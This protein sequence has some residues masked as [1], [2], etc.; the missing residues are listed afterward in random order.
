MVDILLEDMR[1][2]AYHGVLEQEEKVGNDFI[3]SL[4]LQADVD[5]SIESDD[6]NHTIDYA[7]V[8]QVVKEEMTI[9]S[10]LLEHLAGR[11]VKRLFAQFL[12]IKSI[13]IKV[14]K[15]QPPFHS[16]LKAVSIQLTKNRN[17]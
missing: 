2:Y 17:E 4:S 3:V 7:Q 12:S 8:Y 15:P 16:E 13:I 14:S 5:E 1:F 10:N 6:L 9:H 11:I